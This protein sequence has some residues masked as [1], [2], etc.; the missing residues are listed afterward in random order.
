MSQVTIVR[1]AVSPLVIFS[2]LQRAAL[3]G[4][5]IVLLLHGA[6]HLAA[7]RLIGRNLHLP[8]SR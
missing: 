3:A 8:E 2:M 5:N 7:L 1:T 6:G 4:G